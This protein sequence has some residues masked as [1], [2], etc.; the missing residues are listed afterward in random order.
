M[1]GEPPRYVKW[2]GLCLRID[3][4]YKQVPKKHKIFIR[5][6]KHLVTWCS[7]SKLVKRFYGPNWPHFLD[8]LDS[9]TWFPLSLLRELP[10][11]LRETARSAA[12]R[13]AWPASSGRTTHFSWTKKIGSTQDA[14]KLAKNSQISSILWQLGR[15]ASW[16]WPPNAASGSLHHPCRPCSFLRVPLVAVAGFFDMEISLNISWLDG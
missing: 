14:S 13:P 11:I 3:Q 9:Q 5:Q 8:Y 6:K 12:R 1:T 4:N 16:I 10:I 7:I 15:G 2:C